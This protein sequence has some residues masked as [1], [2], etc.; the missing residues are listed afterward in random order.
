MGA[1]Q[2]IDLFTRKKADGS[3]TPRRVGLGDELAEL[4]QWWRRKNPRAEYVFESDRKNHEPYDYTWARKRQKEL[5]RRGEVEYFTLH[6]WRH[7]YASRL[8]SMGYDLV[9]IQALLGHENIRTTSIYLHAISG[10]DV[11]DFR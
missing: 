11:E 3:L 5:C 7:F 1:G 2:W 8:A 9:R 10:I 6:S 4:L